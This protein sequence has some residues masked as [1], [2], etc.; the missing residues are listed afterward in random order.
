MEN[1]KY[2]NEYVQWKKKYI[3]K[4][5]KNEITDFDYSC[6]KNY[7][8]LVNFIGD[9]DIKIN[10]LELLEKELEKQEDIIFVET[11][12]QEKI[13]FSKYL[14]NIRKTVEEKYDKIEKEFI[15]YLKEKLEYKELKI[16]KK[17]MCSFLF[18]SE[19]ARNEN[20]KKINIYGYP[21][22]YEQKYY[23]IDKTKKL[24]RQGGKI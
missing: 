23:L 24:I 14:E 7:K 1:L 15:E 17:I 2:F 6:K 19:Y 22:Y 12:E 10:D 5:I 3:E 16:N 4:V 9:K 8:E 18:D 13:L 20:I 21:Y 11:D